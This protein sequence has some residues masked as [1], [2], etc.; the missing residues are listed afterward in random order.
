MDNRCYRWHLKPPEVR[1]PMGMGL[2]SCA[3]RPSPV[4][5]GIH[6]CL[7]GDFC[8][9]PP[10]DFYPRPPTIGRPTELPANS[11]NVP[12][13]STAESGA[14][15]AAA[16]AHENLG[17]PHTACVPRHKPLPPPVPVHS[18]CLPPLTTHW[19]FLPHALGVSLGLE[20]AMGRSC[21]SSLSDYKVTRN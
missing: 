5:S 12:S 21:S 11:S 2:L 3:E 19:S 7:P 14:S 4:A 20:E 1:P 10:P 18:S 17:N 16:R 9:P 13:T 15:A 6:P 8:L